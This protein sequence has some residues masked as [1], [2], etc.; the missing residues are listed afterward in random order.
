MMSIKDRTDSV[1]ETI[2]LPLF[3]EIKDDART[4]VCVIGGGLSGLS[5]AYELAKRGKSVTLLESF[6]LG[7]GQSGR[8]TAHGSRFNTH[9]T[10]IEGPAMSE[11]PEP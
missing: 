10:A 5:I 9:G 7:S 11:L 6:R 1:W 4:E 2:G 3:T 8:T